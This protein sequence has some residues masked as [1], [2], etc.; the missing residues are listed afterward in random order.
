[1]PTLYSMVTE[2]GNRNRIL[3]MCEF[4]IWFRL[5]ITSTILYHFSPNFA[6]GSGMWSHQTPICDTNRKQ[7]ADFRGV[8]IRISA[9]FRLWWAHFSTD[10]HQIPCTDKIRQCRLCI[11][12]WMK[13][14]I[15]SDFREV[16][17]P[18]SISALDRPTF[19]RTQLYLFSYLIN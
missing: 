4:H 18:V 2:T 3:E 13:W 6:S 10:Q 8:R 12:W 7:F 16:Q 14:E 5:G 9:L 1:M 11:Q 19:D 17:I 15:E